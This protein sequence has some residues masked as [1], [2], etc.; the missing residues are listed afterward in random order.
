MR[1]ASQVQA[2]AVVIA[3]LMSACGAMAQGAKRIW[4]V[5]LGMHVGSLPLKDFVEPGCGNRGGPRGLPLASFG[6]FMQCRMEPGG[7]REVWFAYDDTDEFIGLAHRDPIHRVTTSLLDQPVVLSVLIDESG[8]VRGYRVITDTRA[9]ADLRLHAHEVA[10]HFKARFSL[11]AHCEDLAPEAGESP[12]DG[13]FVKERCELEQGGRRITSEARLY[14]R[15]GQQFLDPNTGLPMANA[16]ESSARLEVLQVDRSQS[17]PVTAAVNPSQAGTQKER[18]LAG[19]SRDCPGCDLSASDLRYRDLAGAS[20]AGA[21]LEG[22]LL[23]GS[24]LR[25]ADLTGAHLHGANLNRASLAQARLAGADLGAAMLFGADLSRADL[26]GADLTRVM[27]GRLTAIGANFSQAK[28]ARADLAE[29][30]LAD[31]DLTGSDLSEAALQRAVLDRAKMANVRLG[32]ADLSQARLRGAVLRRGALASV[33]LTGA[34]LSQ[35][36]LSGVDFR[37]SRLLSAD[38]SGARLEGADFSGARMPDNS[39]AP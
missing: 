17:D 16:F 29:A 25:G 27:A 30:R 19:Q 31:A 13:S 15:A 2:W 20:L 35:A 11:D 18:F 33:D 24:S 34:D 23:H 22:A 1:L 9:P 4:D 28:M 32:R 5:R 38:L 12:M 21:K 8:F 6:D 39:I 37:A 10:I 3:T 26:A 36:D 14:Y 7:L